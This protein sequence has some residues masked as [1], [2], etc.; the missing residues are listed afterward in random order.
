MPK[1]VQPLKTPK[2]KRTVSMR[3]FFLPLFFPKLDFNKYPEMKSTNVSQRIKGF[4]STTLLGGLTIVLPFTLLIIVIRFLFNLV[5]SLADPIKNLI[6]ISDGF[7]GWIFDLIAL[8]GIIGIFFSI[9]LIV[10]TRLGKELWLYFEKKALN[11]L[12]FYVVLRETVQQFFG[13]D[14]MP[15]SK[16]VSVDVFNNGTRML[17]FVSANHNDELFSLFVPTGPNPT[18]G[19]IFIVKKDQ[20]EW[21]DL[22][23]DEAMRIIIGVG[24]GS[25]KLLEILAKQNKQ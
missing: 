23:T 10:Q 17:G 14:K 1:F 15:F 8:T 20:I 16:V 9:G 4:I 11:P 13:K 24:T 2:S 18:N 22:K 25:E 12:P 6:P 7:K 21:L 19:F 5:L 3:S